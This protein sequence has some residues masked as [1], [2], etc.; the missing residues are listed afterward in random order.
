MVPTSP[1]NVSI[2]DKPANNVG[3]ILVFL[4]FG[5]FSR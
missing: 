1:V 4:R 2:N 3:G 5:T